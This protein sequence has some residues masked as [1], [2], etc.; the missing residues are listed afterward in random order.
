MRFIILSMLLV[1]PMQALATIHLEPYLGF[2]NSN[3]SIEIDGDD[4][5]DDSTFKAMGAKLGYGMLG[6]DAGIDYEIDTDAAFT[7][8]SLSAYAAFEFPILFRIWAEYVLSSNTDLDDVDTNLGLVS[9]SSLGV[10]FTGLP[11]IHLNL[12]IENTIYDGEDNGQDY[13]VKWVSYL[14]SVSFPLDF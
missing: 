14:L 9:G 6:F 7:R 4:D 10:G 8:S 5:S 11:L 12:E 2:G 1:L 13:E 3:Y